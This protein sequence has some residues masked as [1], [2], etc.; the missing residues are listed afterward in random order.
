M[1]TCTLASI[2]I[3]G[4]QLLARIATRAAKPGGSFHLKKEAA[5]E[6]LAPLPL[7][8]LPGFGRSTLEKIQAKWGITTFGE[9]RGINDIGAMQR[10]LGAGTG[11]KLW[12]F[13][14]GIDD[15]ELKPDENR[16]TVSATINVRFSS[17]PFC[18]RRQPD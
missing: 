13:V 18:E 5:I 9:A 11:T 16:R 1:S 6:H 7:S 17:T 15:R 3:G 14:R 4:N 12:N 2:G 10:L 8:V